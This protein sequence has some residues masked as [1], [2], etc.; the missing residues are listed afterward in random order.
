MVD[1]GR[2]KELSSILQMLPAPL[3]PQKD[4]HSLN[5][6]RRKRKRGGAGGKGEG[7]E[8]VGGGG[9]EGEGV[10]EGGE[11]EGEEEEGEGGMEV[12]DGDA[13]EAEV[14]V[15]GDDDV[16]GELSGGEEGGGGKGGS[17]EAGAAA[18]LEQAPEEDPFG[19][20]GQKAVAKKKRQVRSPEEEPGKLPG[21]HSSCHE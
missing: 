7:G 14:G 10:K 15:S 9:E 17:R 5:K 16:E 18:P 13:A 19:A 11:V 3:N 21:L 4:P 8:K 6:R 1:P 20:S 2:F 12:R